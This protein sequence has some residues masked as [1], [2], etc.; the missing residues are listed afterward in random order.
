MSTTKTLTTELHKTTAEVLLSNNASYATGAPPSHSDY[1]ST[2]L[3]NSLLITCMDPRIKPAQIFNMAPGPGGARAGVI[4]NAGGR[5]KESLRAVMI[6]Q[7][8]TGSTE[9][10]VMHH[11]GTYVK[12]E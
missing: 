1:Q 6:N 2:M 8:M 5:P 3:C 9:I 10:M 11:T 12:V 4:R 7:M